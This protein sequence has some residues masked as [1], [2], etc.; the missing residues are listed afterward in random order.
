MAIDIDLLKLTFDRA[1]KEN[2]GAQVLGLRFYQRLFEKY[3]GVKPLF[4]TPPEEQHKKLLASI[5]AILASIKNPEQMVPFL[6][7]MGIRHLAYK[8]ENAH[9]G[10]VA[11]NLLAV[12]EEHLSKEGEWTEAMK[13]SWSEA[14]TTIAQIMIE[15]AD[16]PENYTSEL[17]EK[18]YKPDGFRNDALAPWQLAS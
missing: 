14:L 16:N 10:A 11:E 12:L 13:E 18:G 7:A 6:H 5:G 8:T 9:Y 17:A 4:S 1:T 3:P 2:G 15:A